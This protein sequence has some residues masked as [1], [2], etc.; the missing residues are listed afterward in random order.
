MNDRDLD[1]RLAIITC[2]HCG[3]IYDLTK[4]RQNQRPEEAAQPVDDSPPLEARAV[5]P[6]PDKFFIERDQGTFTISWRWLSAKDLFLIPF[7][8]AWNSFLI[9]FL[10]ASGGF[11]F[12]LT[13]HVA[14]GIGLTYKVISDLLNT[15]TISVDSHRLVVR[16]RPLPWWPAP[17]IDVADIEQFYVVERISSGKN[18]TTITYDV[19]AVTRDN[20]SI[21]VLRGLDDVGQALFL[22]QT[23]EQIMNIRD[24]PVAGEVRKAEV[25]L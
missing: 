3:R 2:S 1:R 12:F 23:F 14:V 15:T 16:H 11:D 5:A 9:N 20:S 7:T 6:L 22:E 21:K 25:R 13:A 17:T 10:S 4:E 24:R 18:S 19:L 8:I